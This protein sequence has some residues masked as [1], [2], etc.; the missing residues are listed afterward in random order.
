MTK[1]NPTLSVGRNLF[2]C[3]PEQFDRFV[4][5]AGTVYPRQS[6]LELAADMLGF[7]SGLQDDGTWSVQ[8]KDA[9]VWISG[10]PNHRQAMR[11]W[12][13][14]CGLE[15]TRRDR[16]ANRAWEGLNQIGRPPADGNIRNTPARERQTLREA[17]RKT[18]DGMFDRVS[19]ILCH[20]HPAAGLWWQQTE[21]PRLHRYPYPAMRAGNLRIRAHALRHL[22]DLDGLNPALV[23]M[24][25]GTGSLE[26]IQSSG[27][28]ELFDRIA[29]RVDVGGMVA[30]M[31]VLT[32]LVHGGNPS[33]LFND[34]H[35]VVLDAGFDGRDELFSFLDQ[36][37]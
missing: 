5:E 2:T 27:G 35:Q 8:D 13:M 14:V 24:F 11:R 33:E 32:A 17:N 9:N 26:D 15:A 7:V 21:E 25:E 29:R 3:S 34:L 31:A 36:V 10:A 23:E 16:D 4:R 22:Y 6:D 12:W 18:L 28:E 1:F 19:D 30:R 37:K 20:H